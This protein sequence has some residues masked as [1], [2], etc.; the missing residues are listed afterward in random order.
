MFHCEVVLEKYD[1]AIRFGLS[2]TVRDLRIVTYIFN[3][4]EVDFQKKSTKYDFLRDIFGIYG[5][6][7]NF[8][9]GNQ[10]NYFLVPKHLTPFS[11]AFRSFYVRLSGKLLTR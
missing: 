6:N 3:T 8:K 11:K 7:L 9:G 1:T 5:Q 4:F 2:I 10:T